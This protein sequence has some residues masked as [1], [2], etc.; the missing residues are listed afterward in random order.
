MYKEIQSSRFLFFLSNSFAFLIQPSTKDFISIPENIPI[1]APV[2][3]FLN[4]IQKTN[5]C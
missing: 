4:V 5:R 3:K 1:M 2:A